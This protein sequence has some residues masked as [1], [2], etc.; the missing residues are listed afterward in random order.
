M[1]MDR[2]KGRDEY[3]Q[4]EAGKMSVNR[5]KGAGRICAEGDTR[6]IPII[7]EDGRVGNVA[8]EE[9]RIMGSSSVER[10]SRQANSEVEQG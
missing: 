6:A 3:G 7:W 5:G 2:G 4:G 10:V 8:Y 9:I 1:S